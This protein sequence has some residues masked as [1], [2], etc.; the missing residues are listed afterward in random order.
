LHIEI[1]LAVQGINPLVL[2]EILSA[3]LFSTKGG[4]EF[5]ESR[6]KRSNNDI[7]ITQRKHE[8]NAVRAN[9]LEADIST[10]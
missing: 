1:L 6:S 10:P 9:E 3:I 7:S 2:S 8:T 5:I 4:E